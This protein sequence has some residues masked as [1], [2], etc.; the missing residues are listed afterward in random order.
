M[1]E[2]TTIN[3]NTPAEYG[4]AL[5][6]RAWLILTI[7]GV[8]YAV[9]AISTWGIAYLDF[10]DGQYMY[11]ARRVSQGVTLYEDVLSPQPPL[12]TMIGATLFRVADLVGIEQ[13][14]LLIRIFS[15]LL[16]LGS[17]VLMAL[18]AGHLA[19]RIGLMSDREISL[20]ACCAAF[21]YL[22]IPIGF[23]WTLGYQTHPTLMAILMGTWLLLMLD[24]PWSIAVAGGLA[25]LAPLTSMTSVPYVFFIVL[26]MLLR[27]PRRLLH[28]V[29]P[30]V[31]LYS[32]IAFYFQVMTEGAFLRNVVFN[33]V[34]SFPKEEILGQPL[35]Q[36]AVRK[37]LTYG[38]KVVSL[39]GGFL[40][41]GMT[42]LA[43]WYREAW[44]RNDRFRDFVPFWALGLIGSIAFTSKGATVE[45]IFTIGEPVV[46]VF[47]GLLVG[48][49]IAAIWQRQEERTA[50]NSQS[51]LPAWQSVGAVVLFSGA[52]FYLAFAFN[53]QVLTEEQWELD[54]AGVERV[55]AII[56]EHS[57]PG[58]PLLAPPFYSFISN[59]QVAG[60][61]AEIFLWTIK[62]YNEN[63][64]EEYKDL[65]PGEGTMKVRM[66][67]TMLRRQDIPLVLLDTGQTG[68]LPEIQE[69]LAEAYVESYEPINTMNTQLRVFTPRS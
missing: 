1:T 5:P 57:E 39:E 29:L 2:Q 23:W 58:D 27:H 42:G 49:A 46:C 41:L 59:R 25:A 60:E 15:M 66:L 26:W 31:A 61:Y 22:T 9:A 16:H 10:G 30:L 55:I 21:F 65:P 50:S 12:H 20:T 28:F 51:I 52:M 32:V 69:A 68:R 53:W 34:G 67:A 45:Y 35:W 37:I 6:A 18:L 3:S 62:Y 48:T 14:H 7:M 56:E 8:M 40:V 4:I 33:Q 43:Y 19:R 63:L 36:Y 64:L 13:I 11:V 38:S 24:R 17:A 44:V 54:S 47:A